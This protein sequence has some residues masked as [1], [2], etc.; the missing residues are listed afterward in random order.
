MVTGVDAANYF[1]LPEW[2]VS[3]MLSA[4]PE[5]GAHTFPGGVLQIRIEKHDSRAF[6]AQRRRDGLEI[7]PRNCPMIVLT[8][9]LPINS[10]LR[11]AGYT[12]SAWVT[13]DAAS[14]LRVWT[15]LMTPSGS[16]ASLKISTSRWCVL[17]LS[18]EALKTTVQP[19]ATGVVSKCAPRIT[20]EFHLE[21][22]RADKS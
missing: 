8:G 6:A 3:R 19:T 15:S 17:G 1:N 12:S 18:P 9:A 13:D 22:G 5:L 11:I 20:A 16:P 21:A 2:S 7:L 14:S 10:T 4:F